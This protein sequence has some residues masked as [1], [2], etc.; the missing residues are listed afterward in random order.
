MKKFNDCMFRV[1]SLNCNG[2]RSLERKQGADFLWNLSPELLFFQEIRANT[3]QIPDAFHGQGVPE[4]STKPL[5]GTGFKDYTESWLPAQKKGYSGVGC[6][7]KEPLK[8]TPVYLGHEALD[9]EGRIQQVQYADLT[10]LN[11]YFPSGSAGSHRQKMKM[12]FLPCFKDYLQ[13]LIKNTKHPLLILGDFNIAHRQIDLK[14]W[15][16]NQK[17]PGFLTEERQWLDQLQEMGFCDVVREQL[18]EEE[19][20]S[21]WSQRSGARERNVGWRIDYQW[22]RDPEEK[23]EVV[24]CQMPREPVI[25][26]HAPVVVDYRWR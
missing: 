24:N 20:Y 4:E 25:S 8:S 1:V 7:A 13:K 21:W 11:C 5:N 9:T 18:K 3:E 14:N 2:I 16:Q 6:L 10:I 15:K 12:D 17:K 19:Q 26:D 22:L 23:L